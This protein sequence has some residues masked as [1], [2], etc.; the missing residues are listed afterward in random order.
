MFDAWAGYDERAVGTQFRDAL[1][2]P[3]NERTISNKERAISYAAYRALS[4]I[5]PIDT[6]TLY[7]PM[8]YCYPTRPLRKTERKTRSE[9]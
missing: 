4:D 9:F 5:L 7:K 6:D 3:P 2:R 8:S 1:R